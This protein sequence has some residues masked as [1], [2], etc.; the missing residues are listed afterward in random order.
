MIEALIA[1][2]RDPRVL[3]GMARGRMR[4]KY[5]DLVESLTGQ[6]DDHHAEL[7][8]MLLHQIDTLTDQ[9]DVLTARIEALLA[10][11]PAGNTPDPDR[12]APDGQ[13]RPGTRANAP[14]DEAA[15][16]RTSPRS[17]WT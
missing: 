9:I 2:Q 3:A 17:G 4:L 16:R 13:T 12:P 7:A 11:L 8:R 6:F 15:Q 14:A 10:R 1:G 5:A